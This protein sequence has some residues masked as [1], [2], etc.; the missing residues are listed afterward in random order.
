VIGVRGH[1]L[2]KA[3]R[4]AEQGSVVRGFLKSLSA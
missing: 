4:A 3:H 2:V 1:A